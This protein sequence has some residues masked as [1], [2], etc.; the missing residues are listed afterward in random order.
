MQTEN[1]TYIFG[2]IRE[3]IQ[4]RCLSLVHD[5]GPWVTHVLEHFVKSFLA[6]NVKSSSS[7][8]MGNIL[9][10]FKISFPKARFPIQLSYNLTTKSWDYHE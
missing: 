2:E 6:Y 7:L 4:E 10:N 5:Y 1:V 9:S 3:W 8:F